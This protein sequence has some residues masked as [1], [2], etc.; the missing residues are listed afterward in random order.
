MVISDGIGYTVRLNGIDAP[1]E[2]QLHNKNSIDYLNKTLHETQ[3]K[4]E[5]LPISKKE[6]RFGRIDAV[7]YKDGICVN[8]RMIAHGQAFYYPDNCN[9]PDCKKWQNSE[10][11]AKKNRLGIWT[12]PNY[13]EEPWTFR[14]KEKSSTSNKD[15]GY[16]EG[17]HY[18]TNGI[19]VVVTDP[20]KPDLFEHIEMR[21]SEFSFGSEVPPARRSTKRGVTINNWNDDEF[22][23]ALK[24]K[25]EIGTQNTSVNTVQKNIVDPP[26]NPIVTGTSGQVYSRDPGSG[27]IT[28]TQNGSVAV[29]AGPNGYTD[30]RTGQ[31][32]PTF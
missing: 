17:A 5:I 18:Q 8:E 12:I 13:V 24:R 28:N 25:H 3:S 20:N 7:V 32:M 21:Q 9:N 26:V 30:T 6:D 16:I 1:D 2:G 29:P 4:I 11:E 14:S 27:N 23:E 15:D 22:N 31:F 10:L 19:K